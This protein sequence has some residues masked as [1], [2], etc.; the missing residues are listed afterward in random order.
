M[1]ED[2]IR[3]IVFQK[4]H[5]VEKVKGFDNVLRGISK[6]K[7][8]TL[9]VYYLDY[10]NYNIELEDLNSYQEKMLSSD[11]YN[12]AGSIQWNYYLLFIRDKIQIENKKEIEKDDIYS[13]KYVLLPDELEKFFKY[14][15]TK[16]EIKTDIVIQWKERL[17]KAGLQDVYGKKYYTESINEYINGKVD[18]KDTQVEYLTNVDKKTTIH[19]INHLSLKIKLEF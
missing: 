18:S 2:K 14:E 11:Y 12:I 15:K 9:A 16:D 13:R 7:N 8:S 5:Q 4:L 3:K 6:Y 10:S 1:N 17:R 19:H